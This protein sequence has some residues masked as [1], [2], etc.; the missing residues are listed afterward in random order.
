[1]PTKK[2]PLQSRPRKPF[3]SWLHMH[4]SARRVLTTT[5]RPA[6]ARACVRSGYSPG[7]PGDVSEYTLPS[8]EPGRDVTGTAYASPCHAAVETITKRQRATSAK[9]NERQYTV[10]THSTK[11]TAD[12]NPKTRNC[13]VTRMSSDLRVEAVHHRSGPTEAQ[14][15]AIHTRTSLRPDNSR[16]DRGRTRSQCPRT[17]WASQNESLVEV[18]ISSPAQVTKTKVIRDQVTATPDAQRG[19]RDKAKAERD[20][21]DALVHGAHAAPPHS[22]LTYLGATQRAPEAST[23]TARPPKLFTT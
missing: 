10:I 2:K 21:K 7:L 12:A 23:T 3:T 5:T 15:P 9:S 19:A 13:R 11:K 6:R 18:V 8:G 14:A 1:M 17:A 20:A 16:H 4:N 22:Q